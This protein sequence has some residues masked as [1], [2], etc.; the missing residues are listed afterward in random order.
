MSVEIMGLLFVKVF[1]CSADDL[2][3]VCLMY[4]ERIHGLEDCKF[5]VEYIV[6]R[7]DYEV[8]IQS[9]DNSLHPR[10]K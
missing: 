4:H 1:N 9:V 7:K 2:R 8:R 10:I 5:D 3:K 6:K